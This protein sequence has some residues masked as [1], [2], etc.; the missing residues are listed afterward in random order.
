MKSL[1][2]TILAAVFAGLLP[3]AESEAG[4]FDSVRRRTSRNVS[5]RPR[6]TPARPAIRKPTFRPTSRIRRP[7]TR[8]PSTRRTTTVR[9][10]FRRSNVRNRTFS[11]PRTPQVRRTIGRNPFGTSR[12]FRPVV[13]VPKT[14]RRPFRSTVRAPRTATPR[15]TVRL[16]STRRSGLP[17]RT[18]VSKLRIRIPNTSIR[19]TQSRMFGKRSATRSTST[20][21]RIVRTFGNRRIRIRVPKTVNRANSTKLRIRRRVSPKPIRK[22]LLVGKPTRRRPVRFN[23]N[24]AG[25][26]VVGNPSAAV[27]AQ[28]KLQRSIAGLNLATAIVNGVFQAVSNN[29]NN[30][31]G[32]S[33]PDNVPPTQTW[34]PPTGQPNCPP[35]SQQGGESTT[36]S[37]D[38]SQGSTDEGQSGSF[39]NESGQTE[40]SSNG[41]GESFGSA[42]DS[43]GESG[44]A[45]ES[46]QS[47]AEDDGDANHPIDLAA[48]A[49]KSADLSAATK[50]AKQA[51]Q[52]QP[53]D[54]DTLQLHSL[55]H[56]AD[57]KY[58]VASNSAKQALSVADSWDWEALKSFYR[59][60]ADY[61]PQLRSLEKHTV[62][63]PKD[64]DARFLLAYH[65]LMCGHIKSAQTE[66]EG[67][68]KI[69]P[70][71]PFVAGLLEAVQGLKN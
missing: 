39:S 32:A 70:Q 7:V 42:N 5:R 13:R 51:L 11:K 10:T 57:G 50:Y 38:S 47:G 24:V 18:R 53:K 8:R 43:S 61:T 60:S 28:S 37:G 49:F 67:A 46:T 21:S 66:L 52:A 25:S 20:G 41:D 68:A 63:N 9:P 64:A 16:S 33:Q 48:A 2:I 62:D 17:G 40:G 34:C 26:N 4:P 6:F 19:P 36:G 31:P 65:Y 58:E 14:V 3:I 45:N 15:T 23:G 69:S 35:N 22:S 12:T 59:T 1:K 55:V 71:D 30:N 56:F 44:Q 27:L 54:G 29:Q